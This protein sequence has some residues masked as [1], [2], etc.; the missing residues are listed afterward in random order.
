MK[1][2][3]KWQIISFV[4][5]ILGSIPGWVQSFIYIGLLSKTEWGIVK[6][7]I[8]I[9]GAIGIFQH[10]GLASA[11]TRE[12]SAAKN[13]EEVVK[14]FFTSAVIRYLMSVPLAL[15]LFFVSHYLANS[16]YHDAALEMPFKLY[17]GVLIF[18]AAQS[19]LNSVI[20][21]MQKFKRLFIYQ[22]VISYASLVL[23]IPFVYYY[24][25]NGY[26]VGLLLFNL[27]CSITLYFIAFKPLH[28][29]WSFPTGSEF[30][31]MF[32]ELFSISLAI[33][34]V[35]IIFTNWEGL[36]NNL[37]GIYTTPA[38]LATFSLALLYSKKLMN[39]SDSVTDVSLPIFSE[40]FV[41]NIDEFKKTF[42]KNFDKL[43]A[44]IVTMGVI[45]AF[46]VREIS[47]ILI[48]FLVA[49]LTGKN[50]YSDYLDSF[51]LVLPLIIAYVM[52]SFTN[53]V[54]SSVQI[55][56]KQVKHMIITYVIMIGGTLAFFFLTTKSLGSLEAIS[57]G[58]AVGSILSFLYMAFSVQFTMHFSFFNIDHIAILLQAFFI[59]WAGSIQNLLVKSLLFVPLFALL[60]WNYFIAGF[61]TKAEVIEM[62]NK[63]LAY[64]TL[65]TKK[66]KAS[67]A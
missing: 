7:A 28:F 27:V 61:L 22:T 12:I 46:W 39:I 8:S 48:G 11:S 30:K 41:K 42:S 52:Y 4:S 47:Y 2:L 29:K 37:V 25:V 54:K 57:W 67:K 53:I 9:G 65:I 49:I 31:V 63:F 1:D 43:F 19:L 20:Q 59:C 38:V 33:Y 64:P 15:G 45:A 60:I 40:R 56:A 3:G 36:G 62:K 23:T 35:K 24:K 26:F 51:P 17:S 16:V 13:D 5:R 10:L 21:G 32:R 50:R 66:L 55:P 34:F 58:M 44:V 14:V 6:Q 18:Q